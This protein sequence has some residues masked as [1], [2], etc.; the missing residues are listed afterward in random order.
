M[1]LCVDGKSQ[2]QAL[3]RIQPIPSMRPGTP[4]RRT[5]DYGR[6][7]TTSPFAAIN[8]ATS[9]VSGACHRRHRAVGFRNFLRPIDKAVPADPEVH[10]VLDNHGKHKTAV[11]RQW[12]ARHPGFHFHF[13]PTSVPRFNLI[14]RRFAPSTEK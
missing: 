2:I 5:H 12:P 13:T 9:K 8:T 1:V 3:D 6:Y 10:P 4:E 11:I 7:G 14:E